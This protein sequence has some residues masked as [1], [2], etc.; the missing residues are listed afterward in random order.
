[1][2]ELHQAQEDLF[3]ISALVFLLPLAP[4]LHLKTM[5]KMMTIYASYD[6]SSFHYSYPFSL[7]LFRQLVHRWLLLISYQ[8]YYP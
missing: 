1:M 7:L 3:P 4:P 5:K 6:V 2:Q 8:S